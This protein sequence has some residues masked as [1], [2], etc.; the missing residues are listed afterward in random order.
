FSMPGMMDTVLNIGLNDETATGMIESTGDERFVYDA[1]R[2]LVQMFGS[3]VMGVPDELFEE[4]ITKARIKA[5]VDSDGELT[6]DDWKE[7]I[8]EFK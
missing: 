6:A 5:G 3:V 1:Y 8:K 7:I 2:R 4:K